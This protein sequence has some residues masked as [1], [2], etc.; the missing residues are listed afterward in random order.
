MT[1]SSCSS[2]QYSKQNECASHQ[3][4]FMHT[5]RGETGSHRISESRRCWAG[6]GR[7]SIRPCCDFASPLSPWSNA[8]VQKDRRGF[9]CHTDAELTA[10]QTVTWQRPCGLNIWIWSQIILQWTSSHLSLY[11]LYWSLTINR[12]LHW[13]A[14]TLLTARENNHICVVCHSVA[15]LWALLCILV[16]CNQCKWSTI[17]INIIWHYTIR[18]V[19]GQLKPRYQL[20]WKNWLFNCHPVRQRSLK[21]LFHLD[22]WKFS[23]NNLHQAMIYKVKTICL[24]TYK[25]PGAEQPLM[26]GP[27]YV[28]ETTNF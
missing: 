7:C 28:N 22:N 23:F 26:W 21:P 18:K 11:K 13:L 15:P 9:G 25:A 1:R 4:S 2:L 14:A 10:P 6:A 20:R 3:P 17:D 8:Q 16:H 12:V 24:F 19:K 27:S 5:S